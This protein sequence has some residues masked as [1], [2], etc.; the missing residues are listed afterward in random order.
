LIYFKQV[1][2]YKAMTINSKTIKLLHI[3]TV[4][5]SL[6]FLTNQ[7]G[8]MK[9][10]EFEVQ[11]LSSPGELLDRF[12]AQEN[13]T[14]HAIEMPRR[15]TPIQDIRAIVRL[16]QCIRQIQPQIVHAHTPKGGLLGTIAAFLARVPVR[17][18]HIHGLPLMTA[19]GYKRLLLGWSEKLSCLLANQVFCVSHSIREVVV[20]QKLCPATKVK[21]LL[22]GSINGVD[23]VNR[24]NKANV[25]ETNRQE[26][27]SQYGIPLDALVVGFVGRIV[28]D[29]GIAEL[30]SAWKTLCKEFPKLHLLMVGEFEPQDPVSPEVKHS[31]NHDSR[32]HMTGMTWNTPQL[33]AA[34]D[35]L[36][37][38]TYR[39]GFPVVPLE[40]AAMQLPIVATRIPGCIDAVQDGV[41]GTLVPPRNAEALVEAI[42]AYL[43]NPELRV[44]HGQ[45]GRDRVLRDFRQEAI[46]EALYQE[47]IRLLQEKDYLKMSWTKKATQIFGLF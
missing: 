15:I 19:K 27:C 9:S 31:L 42:R 33:Y 7:V 2:L 47:Y 39:E 34:M 18:Y 30:V 44:Q 38:P 36:V 20:S 28:R 23:A 10:R 22:R 3:T 12:A 40:A 14:V 17:V 45:A 35:V 16:W 26:L 21:V 8:Y 6:Y 24:F 1:I 5:D 4:P 29:K 46:W 25:S 32:I 13:I 41:T 43:Q 11:A 37:L